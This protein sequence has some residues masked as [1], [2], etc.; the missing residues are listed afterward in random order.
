QVTSHV[1][2]IKPQA[3]GY[4]AETAQNNVFQHNPGQNKSGEVSEKAIGEFENFVQLLQKEG[5]SVTVL[6]DNKTPPKPDAV[7]PN[8]WISFHE[9]GTI[10]TYP[11]YSKL[12]REERREDLIDELG[13][14]F[15]IL[16]QI[17]LEEFENHK[18]Y[19]EGTGSMV[20]DRV[21]KI[22]YACISERTDSELLKEW[23]ERM[24]YVQHTFYAL[25]N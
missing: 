5:I 16:H 12:R 20:L 18:Q 22:A 21:N 1:M 10:V 9:D 7:F 3:F 24:G 11:M 25:S 15:R 23:C 4:N 17:H 8:N 2:M 19:L 14:S 13:N 6:E